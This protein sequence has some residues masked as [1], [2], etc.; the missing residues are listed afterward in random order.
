MPWL[1]L[2]WEW[3]LCIRICGESPHSFQALTLLLLASGGCLLC[4]WVKQLYCTTQSCQLHLR[5]MTA[6]M[7]AKIATHSGESIK[8]TAKVSISTTLLQP[9]MIYLCE[10]LSS[11]PLF[12]IHTDRHGIN[13]YRHL[14]R[15]VPVLWHITERAHNEQETLNS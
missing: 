3:P 15:K 7:A 11:F 4:N 13:A 6:T 14:P 10:A 8:H 12:V 1:V 9:P 5:P 2:Q